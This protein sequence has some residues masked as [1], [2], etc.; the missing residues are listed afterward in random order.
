MNSDTGEETLGETSA[1]ASA[2][3][4]PEASPGAAAEGAVNFDEAA[5]VELELDGTEYRMDSGRAGTALCISTRPSGT[6]NWTFRGE[7]RWQSNVLRCKAF[8]RSVLT[9]LSSALAEVSS[10]SD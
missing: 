3:T 7:A 4:S 8:D 6:W 10:G 9:Q 2:E 5:L 1:D